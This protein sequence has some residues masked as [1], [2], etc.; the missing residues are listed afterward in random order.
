MTSGFAGCLNLVATSVGDDAV[1][2][3][4]SLAVL[5]HEGAELDQC[6]AEVL[7]GLTIRHSLGYA[8]LR[9][10]TRTLTTIDLQL[11]TDHLSGLLLYATL[12]ASTAVSIRKS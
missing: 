3:P 1:L 6:Y 2:V 12:A 8:Q 5:Q 7:P 9:L 11:V 10:E 4:L